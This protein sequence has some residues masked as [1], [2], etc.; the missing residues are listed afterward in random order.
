MQLLFGSEEPKPVKVM[1]HPHHAF[2]IV[3]IAN[4]RDGTVGKYGTKA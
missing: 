4:E 3:I 2:D 1:D